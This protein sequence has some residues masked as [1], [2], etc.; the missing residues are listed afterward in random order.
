MDEDMN[1]YLQAKMILEKEKVKVFDKLYAE[2]LVTGLVVAVNNT[3]AIV[4]LGTKHTGYVAL[5]DLTYDPSK[6]PSDI[7]HVGDEFE[8]I[9]LRVN[10]AEGTARLRLASL[11]RE[12]EELE[13][14]KEIQR[15]ELKRQK[16][17]Q[18]QAA[19]VNDVL[20]Q[21]QENLSAM[22]PW[23]ISEIANSVYS[24]LETKLIDENIALKDRVSELEKRILQLERIIDKL[25]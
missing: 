9:V 14:Q 8:F 4:D 22:K 19:I 11:E 13:R 7:A 2:M 25:K 21:V 5:G 18:R 12:R 6:K 15:Q 16:E 20:S 24:Q 1:D 3:E 17:K 10:D 23:L